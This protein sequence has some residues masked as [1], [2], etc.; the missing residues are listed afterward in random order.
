[1]EELSSC[2]KGGAGVGTAGGAGAFKPMMRFVTLLTVEAAG[3]DGSGAGGGG[4]AVSSLEARLAVSVEALALPKLSFHRE[5]FF[6]GTGTGGDDGA[7]E[8]V[9]VDWEV[10]RAGLSNGVGIA[11][12]ET[13]SND[14]C[15]RDDV[16]DFVP[17][18]LTEGALECLLSSRARD[19]EATARVTSVS[20]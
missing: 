18:D 2:L 14:C 19:W 8:V 15:L 4:W 10:V 11:Y 5:G 13:G 9:D 16:V 20:S 6:V 17:V 7:G 3:C 1:M 12:I